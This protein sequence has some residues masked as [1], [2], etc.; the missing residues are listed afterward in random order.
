MK[1][2]TGPRS[3]PLNREVG[4]DHSTL[5]LEASLVFLWYH[6]SLLSLVLFRISFSPLRKFLTS[7]FLLSYVLRQSPNIQRIIN[8]TRTKSCLNYPHFTN[9]LRELLTKPIII[10]ENNC[11]LFIGRKIRKS[12]VLLGWLRQHSHCMNISSTI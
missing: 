8:H 10:R 2:T 6:L 1:L 9:R 12:G 3:D 7:E 11:L 5:L 4:L